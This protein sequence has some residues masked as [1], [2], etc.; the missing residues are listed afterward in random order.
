[1]N[2]IFLGNPLVEEVIAHDRLLGVPDEVLFRKAARYYSFALLNEAAIERLCSLG[3]IMDMGC[4]AGYWT[5]RLRERGVDIIG[6]EP[7]PDPVR[8]YI[9]DRIQG[10]HR[11]AAAHASRA[12]LMIWPTQGAHWPARAVESYSGRTVAYVGD[13]TFSLTANK[14]FPL[15]LSRGGFRA[16]TTIPINSWSH[17]EHDS[18]TIYKR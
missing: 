1:M 14:R 3:P 2:G 11:M 12:L 17:V 5:W 16:A 4:G 6:I 9:H 10:D 8:P 18:L 13:P 15:A 7:R